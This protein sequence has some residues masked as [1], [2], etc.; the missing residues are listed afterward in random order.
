METDPLMP[1]SPTRKPRQAPPPPPQRSSLSPLAVLAL[2]LGLSALWT[3]WLV[4]RHF[5]LPTPITVDSVNGRAVFNEAASL[6]TIRTLAEDRN[7][8]PRYRI[9]GTKD[10]H[11]SECV[12]VRPGWSRSSSPYHRRE[13]IAMVDDIKRKHEASDWA[14][15]HQIEVWHQVDNGN[16]LFEF[17]NRMVY[18]KYSAISNVIVRLSDGTD[19]SKANAVLVNAHLD[20][21]LPSPGAADD[22][23]GV[24]VMLEALRVL[25]SSPEP[26]ANSVIFLFNGAEESLQDASHLYITKHETKDT[27]RAV[28]NLEAC[29]T[30]GAEVPSRSLSARCTG[31]ECRADPVSGYQRARGC[32]R[33]A[34]L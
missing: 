8:Q 12:H 32:P 20:S 5:A 22:G 11:D 34:A 29:G 19:A 9:V 7:G 21:T 4:T 3:R 18:K 23:A 16:H 10:F 24:G 33:P 2:F 13:L 25:A 26:L 17:M 15:L 27:V 1:S 28:I 30:T 6:R 14:K 31:A